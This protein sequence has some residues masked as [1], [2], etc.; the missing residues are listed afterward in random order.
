MLTKVLSL[1]AVFKPLFGWFLMQEVLLPMQ[2][3]G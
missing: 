3:V 1:K 2:L